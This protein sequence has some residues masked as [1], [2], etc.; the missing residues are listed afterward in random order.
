MEPS[1]NHLSQSPLVD[2]SGDRFGEVLSRFV[3]ISRHDVYEILEEQSATRRKFGQ[4][5]LNWQLCQPQHVWQAWASQL[6]GRTPRIDLERFGVDSQ[7]A[8]DLPGW[9]A[10]ALG[11]VPV[12]TMD[13][14][15]VVA[16]S[17]RSLPRAAELLT[18]HTKKS[19]TFVIADARQVEAAV[20]RYYAN[21]AT[22]LPQ[23]GAFS[24][25]SGPATHQACAIKRCGVKCKGAA[26]AM[27]RKMLQ[28][29][30]V[31]V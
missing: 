3:P 12:R 29:E 22:D 31:A 19:L 25:P 10:V 7:A 26:C 17:E 30:R 27:K 6:L 21:L 5:A 11:V 14:M 9:V 2:P 23:R 24:S 1:F 20:Q 15:L 28:P 13:Q 4:I 16:A 8:A 18:A